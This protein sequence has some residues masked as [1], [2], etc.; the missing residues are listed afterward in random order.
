MSRTV[1][2]HEIVR[3]LVTQGDEPVR[4]GFDFAVDRRHACSMELHEIPEIAEEAAVA[5][6]RYRRPM[7][8]VKYVDG[9]RREAE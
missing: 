2:T 4:H 1:V 7:F 9:G 5:V 3:E 6:E 8:I